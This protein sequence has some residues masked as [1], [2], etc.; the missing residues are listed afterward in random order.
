MAKKRFQLAT[1]L[2]GISP[3]LNTNILN[4]YVKVFSGQGSNPTNTFSWL[5]HFG[6]LTD[7]I[8]HSN[9]EVQKYVVGLQ[10]SP[11]IGREQAQPQ[12]STWISSESTWE[13]QLASF[14][15]HPTLSQLKRSEKIWGRD[16]G[17]E[18]GRGGGEEG[19][20]KLS[21]VWAESAGCVRRR[22]L[23]GRGWKGN[24]PSSYIPANVQ[25]SHWRIPF[26]LVT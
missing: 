14:I 8:K 13:W 4:L 25:S 5:Y 21:W 15:V 19:G 10:L 23:W 7:I 18:V 11:P 24:L 9:E 1:K 2:S 12:L 3:K 17:A 22:G 16:A 26:C 20:V 6:L